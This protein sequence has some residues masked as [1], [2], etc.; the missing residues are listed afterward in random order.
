MNKIT[1]SLFFIVLVAAA[2][3][4]Y[5]HTT[6]AADPCAESQQT[7]MGQQI[8]P[9]RGKIVWDSSCPSGMRW[10]TK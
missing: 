10:K 9:G 6:P 7:P 2:A 4:F 8:T 3:L 5:Q 1:L